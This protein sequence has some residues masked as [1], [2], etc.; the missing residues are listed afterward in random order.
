MYYIESNFFGYQIEM[1]YIVSEF[2]RER[3]GD[4]SSLAANNIGKVDLSSKTEI[5]FAEVYQWFYCLGL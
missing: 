2:L 5:S 4:N 3:E 1:I